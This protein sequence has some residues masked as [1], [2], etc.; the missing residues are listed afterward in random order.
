MDGAT[1]LIIV[2]IVLLY[3]IVLLRRN[4][5]TDYCNLQFA[6]QDKARQGEQIEGTFG[7]QP[8]RTIRFSLR[9]RFYQIQSK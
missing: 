1:T 6:R 8:A 3:C 2:I 9:S 7:Q 4:D 5:H